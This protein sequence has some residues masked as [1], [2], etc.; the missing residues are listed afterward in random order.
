MPAGVFANP[1][2]RQQVPA[3]T[4]A[5]SARQAQLVPSTVRQP[6]LRADQQR[7]PAQDAIAG[8]ASFPLASAEVISIRV[9][10]QPEFSG[11]YR[12]NPDMT[13]SIA[14]LG[15]VAAGAMTAAELERFLSERL[16]SLLRQ[17]ISA[18]VEVVRFRPFF[19]TGQVATPGSVEWR[20]G[21][22]LIQA[23]SLSGGIARTMATGEADTPEQRLVLEQAKVRHSFALAQ[24]A[25]FKAEKDRKESIEVDLLL[26]SYIVKALPE[27]R[28]SLQVFL[29]R[30]NQLLEEQRAAHESRLV[31]MEREREAVLQELEAARGQSDEIK[32]QV[33]LVEA[34][35]ESIE[36]LKAQQ[37]VTNSR[38]LEQR[39]A[40]SEIRVRYSESISL[41][42]RARTRYNT[43]ERDIVTLQKDRD[44]VLNDRI[45]TLENEVS[46]LELTLGEANPLQE[47][48]L[49]G[50][51]AITY[52]IARKSPAG[53]QTFVANLFSEIVP[54]DVV[55]VSSKRRPGGADASNSMNASSD[56]LEETQR[57]M[58]ASTSQ[59]LEPQSREALRAG[60]QPIGRP[61]AAVG[62]QFR[63]PGSPTRSDPNGTASIGQRLR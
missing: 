56:A 6:D 33:E 55:I 58:E 3:E 45:E 24:L 17:D 35:M 42:Q 19:I 59:G 38:Y 53:L 62:H 7:G 8:P 61:A 47:A 12:I 48:S 22:T 18:A 20:P 15:R 30:Q 51:S 4:K 41:V 52:H 11:D 63:A 32:L 34:Q 29:A 25:R 44:A 16:G 9:R 26:N 57:L 10:E 40:M 14:R 54:G 27:T 39:R 46:Q 43:V 2:E 21:L 60:R 50:R 31:G 36:S 13:I 23:I 49:R 37:L 1:L 28:E 5:P